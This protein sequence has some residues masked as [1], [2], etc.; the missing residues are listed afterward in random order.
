MKIQQVLEEQKAL[1]M[2]NVFMEELENG[3]TTQYRRV[4]KACEVWKKKSFIAHITLLIVSF[5]E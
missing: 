2:L 4:L 1:E 3:S 5:A